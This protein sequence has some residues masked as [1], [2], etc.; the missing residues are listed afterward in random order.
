MS[1]VTK[2]AFVLAIGFA[3][4]ELITRWVVRNF[5]DKKDAVPVFGN[6]YIANV[7][8]PNATMALGITTTGWLVIA[9]LFSSSF[10]LLFFLVEEKFKSLDRWGLCKIGYFASALLVS[11]VLVNTLEAFSLGGVSDYLAFIDKEN[12]SALVINLA[13]LVLIVAVLM[14]PTAFIALVSSSAISLANL[15]K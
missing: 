5:V 12:K 14:L 10:L 15:G 4:F 6:A 1:R 2:I 11:V 8:N 9:L 3:S 13:D 7:I